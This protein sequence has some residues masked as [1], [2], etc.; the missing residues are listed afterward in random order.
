MIFDTDV[1]IWYLRGN[2]AANTLIEKTSDR[3][4]SLQTQLELFQGVRSKTEL[5]LIKSLLSDLDVKVLPLSENIGHRAAIYIEEYSLSHGL[6]SQDAIIAATATEHA[7]I[8]CS[9]NR[10]HFSCIPSIDLKV[11]KPS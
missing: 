2:T 1:L 3:F 11:F 10:K 5:R 7:E 9:A 4:I 8:L 6:Q